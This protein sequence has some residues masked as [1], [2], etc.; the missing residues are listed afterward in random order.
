MRYRELGIQTLR[1]APNLARTEGEAFLFR[2]AFWTPDGAPTPLAARLLARLKDLFCSLNA[3]AF[4][5]ALKLPVLQDAQGNVFVRYP[6]GKVEALHC[7]TCGYFSPRETAQS[8]RE[9]SFEEARPVERVLTPDCNT[10]ES[11]ARYLGIPTTRTAKAL[12]FTREADGEFLFVVVRGDTTLNPHKLRALVGEVR[13]A[14]AEEIRA[15][16]AVPGYAS[17]IGLRHGRVLVDAWIPLS[18]N[19][20]AGANEEGYHLRNVNYGRDFTADQVADLIWAEAGDRCLCGE[21]RLEALEVLPLLVDGSLLE[22]NLLRALAETHHDEQGLRWPPAIAPFDVYLLHVPGK[23]L[24]TASAAISLAQELEANGIEVLLDDR[25]ERA[26]V[27][28]TDADLLGIP[29][30]VTV[31]ERA[32]KEG[33]VEIKN[34]LNGEQERVSVEGVPSF[35]RAWKSSQERYERSV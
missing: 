34:R 21:G 15:A 31:G 33:Q 22:E 12:M 3:E 19:L 6:V 14:T 8:A 20:V 24:D 4:F 11:L 28:F 2:A 10:I 5:A 26:G 17:P 23:E 25:D 32:L 16:G 1:Q 35:F 9:A 7:P 18:P 13:L 27:K 30:R 29:W